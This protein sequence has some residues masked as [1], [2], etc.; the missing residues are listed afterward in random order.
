MLIGVKEI[1]IQMT[2]EMRLLK[3]IKIYLTKEIYLVI[4]LVYINIII[5]KIKHT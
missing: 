1:I 5:S 2:M 4:L 3:H